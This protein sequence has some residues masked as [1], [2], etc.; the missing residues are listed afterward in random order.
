M[1][2]IQIKRGLQAAVARLEPGNV[3]VGTTSGKVHINPTGGTADTA[4]RLKTPRAFSAAGD[5]TA[6]AVNFDGS[7]DVRLQLVLA[8]LSGLKAGT[9]TKVTVNNKGQVTAGQMLEVSDIPSIPSSKVTG[10]GTAAAA[11]TG[12][13]EGN[14]P[15]VQA[16]GKLLASLLRQAPERE[17]H[18]GCRRRGCRPSRRKGRGQRRRHP[19]E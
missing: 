10:L 5:A 11:N 4:E 19:G 6:E 13:E 3:Y 1:A 18:P 14:V 7:A 17:C 9:Y 16:G 12:A 2:K 15:V 8:A